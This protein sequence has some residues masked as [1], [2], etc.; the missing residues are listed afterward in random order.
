MKKVVFESVGNTLLF[1]LMG[2]C[3]LYTSRCV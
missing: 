3:L 1:A 2:L